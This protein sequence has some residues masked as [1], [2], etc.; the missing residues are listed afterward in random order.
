[1]IHQNDEDAIKNRILEIRERIGEAAEKAGVQTEDVLVMA[2]TK[3]VSP[4]NVNLAIQNGISLLGENRVQE[5]C[6]KYESYL[7]SKCI[8]FIGHL[9]SNKVKYIID[10]VQMIESVDSISLAEEID[11]R[12]KQSGV[13]MPILLQVNISREATKSGFMEE[14]VFEIAKRVCNLSSVCLQGLMCIPEKGSTEAGFKRME[15]M[16]FKFRES[17]TLHNSMKLLSMGMS[18]DYAEAVACHSN[19]VR[20][21]S[22]IFG[23]RD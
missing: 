9:Q 6:D 18:D 16:F 7:P 1:M 10:R 19:L 5:F 22:A 4:V 3:T 17:T 11:I 12:A 2:V 23:K 20:L 21:G 15:E 14:E 8:H 13:V